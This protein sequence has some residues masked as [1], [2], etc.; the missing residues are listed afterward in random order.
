MRSIG[1]EG[2]GGVG[3]AALSMTNSMMAEPKPPAMA[4]SSS[5]TRSLVVERASAIR[6]VSRGLAKRM[7]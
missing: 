6:L 4:P 7:S 3:C 2:R 1:L 5:V